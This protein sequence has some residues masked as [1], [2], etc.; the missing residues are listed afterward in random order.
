M[1]QNP[2][3]VQLKENATFHLAKAVHAL[4]S[5]YGCTENLIWSSY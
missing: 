3:L 1:T 2:A 4:N 5:L